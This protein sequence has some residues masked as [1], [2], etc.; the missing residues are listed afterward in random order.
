MII[1]VSGRASR[2]I[3]LSYFGT[4]CLALPKNIYTN[5]SFEMLQTPAV[6]YNHSL[7]CKMKVR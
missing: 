4:S 1:R 7:G 5:F 2:F 3:G 6:F